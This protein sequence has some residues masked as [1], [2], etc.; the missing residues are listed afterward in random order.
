MGQSAVKSLTRGILLILT[1]LL[2]AFTILASLAGRYHPA[3]S[4]F[5]PL[6][7]LALPF[8]LLANALVLVVFLLMR[9]VQSLIPLLAILANWS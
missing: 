4:T 5:M 1:L 3:E 6:L 7:G 2:A 8:L 9:K